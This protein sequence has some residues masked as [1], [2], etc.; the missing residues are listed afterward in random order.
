[1][2]TCVQTFRLAVDDERNMT[3]RYLTLLRHAH[4][5]PAALGQSD[6]D[7]PLDA[8]GLA[9]LPIVQRRLA[10][11]AA[12]DPDRML[13]SSA[14]RTTQ[15]AANIA[16]AAQVPTT[17][18][19]HTRDAYLATAS[20]LLDLLRTVE[21]EVRHVI[22]VAHNPGISDLIASLVDDVDV[23]LPTA[24]FAH[25]Q[26]HEAWLELKTAELLELG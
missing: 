22:L 10:G 14:V 20:G 16:A 2:F 17:S 26:V 4:A 5:A 3:T 15:T 11:L 12:P 7:R 24:G 25:L 1:M 23:G 13:V 9:Q 6:F 21:P 18:I 19:S 8:D